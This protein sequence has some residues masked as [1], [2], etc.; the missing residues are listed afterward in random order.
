MNEIWGDLNNNNK[1]TS[2][3][4]GVLYHDLTLVN[5]VSYIEGYFEKDI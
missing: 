1:N 4:N 3:I 5:L 2:Y